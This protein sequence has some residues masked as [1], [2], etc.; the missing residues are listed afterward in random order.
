MSYWSDN[1]IV[2][3]NTRCMHTEK[4]H[5]YIKL[6]KLTILA[7]FL[8]IFDDFLELVSQLH[9]RHNPHLLLLFIIQ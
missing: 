1:I 7:V 2:P 5:E 4:I 3:Y 6:T 9:L 8:M